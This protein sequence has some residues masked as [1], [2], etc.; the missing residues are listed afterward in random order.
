VLEPNFLGTKNW[1]EALGSSSP[2]EGHAHSIWIVYDELPMEHHH[3]V[4]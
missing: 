3:V 2:L 4:I 1:I